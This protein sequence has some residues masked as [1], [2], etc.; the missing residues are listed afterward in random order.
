MIKNKIITTINWED[1]KIYHF[2]DGQKVTLTATKC[3]GELIKRNEE[4]VIL[5]NCQQFV[6]NKNKFILKRKVRFFY[7]PT[8]MIVNMT[9]LAKKT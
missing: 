1:A 9:K 5:K 4:F 8:G 2:S 7:I 3:L 6:R